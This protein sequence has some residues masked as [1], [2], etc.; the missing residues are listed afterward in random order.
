M[1][2]PS[3]YDTSPRPNRPGALLRVAVRF[4]A[5]VCLA[6]AGGVAFT[7]VVPVLAEHR[8][9]LEEEA[10]LHERREALR[11]EVARA[12]NELHWLRYDPAY[13]EIHARDRLDLQRPGEIVVRFPDETGGA[14]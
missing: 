14:H 8:Q 12:R 1:R 13:Y 7:Y 2:N 11:R 5:V 9:A 10:A 4:L 6:S 3:D